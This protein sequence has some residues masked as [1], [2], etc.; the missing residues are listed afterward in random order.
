M[1]VVDFVL[2]TSI[3]I[4]VSVFCLWG[5]FKVGNSGVKKSSKV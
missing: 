2:G 4:G 3:V 1:S 5:M